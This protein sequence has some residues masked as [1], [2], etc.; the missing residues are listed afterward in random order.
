M[1][2]KVGITIGDP[3]G[4]GPEIVAKALSSPSVRNLAN[5][6]VIGDIYIFR[7]A[8]GRRIRVLSRDNIEFVDL[9]NVRKRNFRF[10]R[11]SA[12]YGRASIEYIDTAADLIKKGF[13]DCLVTA[14]VNKESI[15]KAGSRFQ[16]HT[17]YLAGLFGVRKFLMLLMAGRLRIALITRHIPVRQVPFK[18]NK[19]DIVNG[20]M[21]THRTLR[22]LFGFKKPLIFVC[23]LNPHASDGGLIG[24]EE[25][26]IIKPA[27]RAASKEIKGIRGPLP[28]DTAILLAS[29]TRMSAAVAMYH[30]QALIPL[31]LFDTKKGVNLTAGLPFVRTSPLHGTGFDIAGCGMADASSIIEAIKTAIKCTRIQRSA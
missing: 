22:I 15:N 21:L 12:E 4:I 5:F 29:R 30:D 1:K 8:A 28:S 23:G 17:E 3:S 7:R 26:T 9:M 2:V 27:V 31:K 13:V 18:I 25:S 14:P 24:K 16:G 20:I 6:I 10:G 11:I 19:H